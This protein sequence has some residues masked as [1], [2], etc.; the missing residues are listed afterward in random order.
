MFR[1]QFLIFLVSYK[2]WLFGVSYKL[3]SLSDW[4]LFCFKRFIKIG[5]PSLCRSKILIFKTQNSRVH[6]FFFQSQKYAY[7]FS[8][9]K[10][11]KITLDEFVKFSWN[12][13]KVSGKEIVINCYKLL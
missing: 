10:N 5:P 11:L 2:I 8:I 6:N 12:L 9:F 4:W 3:Y 7:N 13:P 1:S